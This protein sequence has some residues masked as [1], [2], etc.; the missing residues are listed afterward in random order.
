MKF[1]KIILVLLVVINLLILA[2][3]ED[4]PS[5][6]KTVA[7]PIF[8]PSGGTYEGPVT[9]SMSCETE[10]AEIY[11]T[12]DGSNPDQT[13]SV[14]ADSFQ[15]DESTTIKARAYKTEWDASATVV[16]DYE[17]TVPEKFV[18]VEGG[19]FH[20]GTANATI[21]DFY[22]SKYEVT[23]AE[24]EAVMGTN[25]ALDYGVGNDY[26][27]YYVSWFKAIKYC[28][29]LSLQEGLTPCYNYNNEGTDPNEWSS[30]W[31][32]IYNHTS[33]VFDT[34]ANG[35]RLP[36]EMEWM[37]AA[38]GGNQQPASGYNQYSGTD[39]EVELAKFAWYD[40]TSNNTTHEVGT[41][42]PNQ[43]GLYD[44]SG[45]VFEW[46]WDIYNHPYSSSTQTDPVG[47]TTGLYRVCRGGSWNY[48]AIPCGVAYRYS[49]NP[50]FSYYCLGFRLAR[51]SSGLKV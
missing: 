33:Y 51:S 10:D 41:R 16:A 34:T 1:R 7:N 26:P 4:N 20:N 43:L 30:G 31:N 47:P 3:S 46:C 37:Y 11:Y 22:M 44:M 17:I 15:L 29:I 40:Y 28:N 14:Y 2:C 19:T 49:Y 12:L 8:S 6:P 45:N 36:T 5:K 42:L 48:N 27:V 38:K 32:S 39:V 13:A 23:Q 50:T 24:Y 35:Y 21:S 9:V 18:L 25:P